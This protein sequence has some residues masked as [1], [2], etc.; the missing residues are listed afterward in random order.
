MRPLHRHILLVEDDESNREL[1][2]F[3]LGKLGCRVTCAV[4]SSEALRLAQTEHFDLYLL[5]DWPPFGQESKLCE[6][7]NEFDPRGPIL[8]LS[9]AAYPADRRRR[10]QAGARGYLTKPCDLY[11][12]GQVISHVFQEAWS[13]RL[14]KRGRGVRR[15]ESTPAT[16]S[17]YWP[18]T[19]KKRG[20]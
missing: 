9:T 18:T 13:Y 20:G 10:M 6:Q 14:L 16:L 1:L 5:G 19:Y 17:R 3:F 4:T 8:F 12:L 15:R 7:I 2:T 11:D